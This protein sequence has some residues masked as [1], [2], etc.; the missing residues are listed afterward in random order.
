MNY[1]FFI[2]CGYLS[3]SVLY[4]Y[5]LPKHLCHI[6][7]TAGSSDQNPGT[8]N[9]F[10]YAGIPVGTAVLLLELSKAFFP[11]F[12]AAR[13]L[14]TQNPLFGLVLAAPVAGHAFP[15]W[16]SGKGGKSI[17]A[18]F[19]ALLGLLPQWRPVVILAVLYIV[20]SA[21]I[22]IKP[23]FFRSVVTFL[24][25]SLACVFLLPNRAYLLGCALL[26]AIVISKHLM[27]YQGERITVQYWKKCYSKK[28]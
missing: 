13:F 20:F 8:A 21:V 10:T 2:V 4:A 1:L 7:I 16:F 26:S 12:C 24:L 23:H 9:A 25:F 14:D 15:L 17:A 19:G 27:M 5:L 11:V 18:S 22:L 3:G 28:S 6:D